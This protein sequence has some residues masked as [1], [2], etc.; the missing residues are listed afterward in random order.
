M[1]IP[2]H[3]KQ[4]DV[5]SANHDDGFPSCNSIVVFAIIVFIVSFVFVFVANCYQ[6]FGG[7]LIGRSSSSAHQAIGGCAVQIAI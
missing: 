3:T 1:V 6:Q 5:H 2:Q 7:G 4:S